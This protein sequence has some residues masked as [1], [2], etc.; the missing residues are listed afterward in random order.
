MAI[1]F[2]HF[3]LYPHLSSL[4][5]ITLGLRHGLKLSKQEARARAH[6]V[7]TRM[8]VE[9]LLARKPRE[10]SG[11]QRQRIALARALARKS[12]VVLLDEPLSGLDAQLHAALRVEIAELLRSVN[13][14][15]VNVTH[16]Q[17]DAMAM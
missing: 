15:G 5:N 12:G 2:Q 6:D 4:D 10:M 11:G 13:A 16:D 17:V 7:A 14:T 9:H 8:Q 3:A 1:V